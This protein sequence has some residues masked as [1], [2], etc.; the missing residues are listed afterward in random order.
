MDEGDTELTREQ[1][2]RSLLLGLYK[3]FT[4]LVTTSC[5]GYSLETREKA[6]SLLRPSGSGC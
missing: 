2:W 5:Q 3:A 4:Y 1:G 6:N